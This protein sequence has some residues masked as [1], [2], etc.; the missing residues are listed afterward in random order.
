MTRVMHLLRAVFVAVGLPS[1]VVAAATPLQVPVP[2]AAKALATAAI[3]RLRLTSL[4]DHCLRLEVDDEGTR[5]VITVHE[6]HEPPC[7]GD[8]EIEPRLFSILV[9]KRDG[10]MSSDVYDATDY[11]PLDHPLR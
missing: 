3:H 4:P 7:A 11:R 5:F 10:R 8:P 6:R 1:V 2:Q 9:R